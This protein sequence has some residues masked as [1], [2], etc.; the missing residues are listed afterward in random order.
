[1]NPFQLTGA[2]DHPLVMPDTPAVTRIRTAFTQPASTLLVY[3][4]RRMGKRAILEQAVREVVAVRGH[5]F[6]ADLSTV[7]TLADGA[8]R[9]LAAASQALGR[10]WPDVAGEFATRLGRMLTIHPEPGTGVLVPRLAVAFRRADVAQQREA[11]GRVL[12]AVDAMAAA[13]GVTIGIALNE[14]QE[15][16][17]FGGEDAE[18][19]LRDVIRHHRHVSYVLA[20]STPSLT[21]RLLDRSRTFYQLLEPL[22]VG[23][24]DPTLLARWIEEQMATAGVAAT[25]AG[26]RIVAVAGPRT[27]DVVRLARTCFD[28]GAAAGVV[29]PDDVAGAFTELVAGREDLARAFWEGCTPHQ[30][31]VLRAVAVHATGLTTAAVLERFGLRSTSATAHALGG[32]V[33]GE[34]LVR[35]PLAREHLVGEGPERPETPRYTYDSPYLRGWVLVHALPDIGLTL[36]ITRLPGGL[37]A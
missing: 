25:G 22:H 23:P 2:V 7:S 13:R 37:V 4:A 9:L 26:A 24:V 29:R 14:F 10:S 28:R 8:N 6:V 21:R 1:M 5:A 17:R 31:N 20:G 36:P 18:W 15:L 33:A 19:H 32:L 35:E 11:L 3:G 16:A 34:H 30:Q 27:R 12:D